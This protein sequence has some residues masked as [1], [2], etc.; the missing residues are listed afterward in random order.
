MRCWSEH[1]D[2]NLEPDGYKPPALPLRYIP[3]LVVADRIEL[4]LH[5]Y[6]TRFLPLK[7]ATMLVLPEGIEPT[8][9]Y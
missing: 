5:A 6:Q 7:D 2:L 3:K 1:K 8:R 4:P 9:T